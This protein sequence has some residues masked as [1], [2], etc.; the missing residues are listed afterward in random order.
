MVFIV[1]S[2][3]A[4]VGAAEGTIVTQLD[5]PRTEVEAQQVRSSKYSISYK[6]AHKEASKIRF[7]VAF[8]SCVVVVQQSLLEVNFQHNSQAAFPIQANTFVVFRKTFP[9]SSDE[10][11]VLS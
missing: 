11:V 9:Q 6:R 2:L 8:E 3:F 5:K 4:F 1:V 7:V 10:D